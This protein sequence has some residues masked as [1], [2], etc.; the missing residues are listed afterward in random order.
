MERHRERETGR[1]VL[2]IGLCDYRGWEVQNLQCGSRGLGEPMV[3]AAP[4][5]K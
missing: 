2:G 5:Q 4:I 1:F 3:H